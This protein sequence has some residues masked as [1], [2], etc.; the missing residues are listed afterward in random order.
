[1]IYD[2][3]AIGF[4]PSNV[5][6]AIALER[7][8]YQG[9]YLFLEKNSTAT[10]HDQMLLENSDI[11]NNPLRDL[12]TPVDPK[13]EYTFINYLH[14]NG[15]LLEYL[16]L[17]L[18]YPFRKDFNNYFKWV[19]N[20]FSCVQY[21]MEVSQ[22]NISNS[23]W[24][25]KLKSGKILRCRKL[26]I[27]TGRKLNIPNISGISSSNKVF[28]LVEYLSSIKGLSRKSKISVL[29]SSQSA[30]EILLDLYNKGFENITS[31]HRSFAFRLKD[32]SPFSDKVY[33]PKFVDYYHALTSQKR[34]LLDKQV[35]ATNYSSADRDVIDEL[36]RCMYRSKL[37]NEFPIEIFNNNEIVKVNSSCIELKEIYT[38]EN[39][40]VEFDLLILAT[41]FLDIG[42]SGK[43]GLPSILR[44]IEALFDWSG[45][46]LNVNRDYTVKY[47]LNNPDLDNLKIYLNGLCES[48]HGLGDAGS[49]SLVSIRAQD[50]CKS[51]MEE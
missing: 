17:G 8:N 5:A 29:G 14:S 24:E 36:Y 50:I 31:I 35:R 4:G 22:I 38:D 44:P 15:S 21:N 41:G 13:S 45:N 43:S 48:S 23:F 39:R 51:I 16:N 19:A 28:H 2:L 42:R 26:V 40:Q 6:L 32:T 3:L 30:A 12:I 9:K 34:E 7:A 20:K 1:M 49:F 47:S 10:W 27:G 25:L 11:Q 18:T 46:Y 37:D 33:F